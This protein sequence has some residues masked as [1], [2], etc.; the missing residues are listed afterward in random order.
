MGLKAPDPLVQH[1]LRHPIKYVR[2]IRRKAPS[3]RAQGSDQDGNRYCVQLVLEGYAFLKPKHAVAGTAIIGL[4]IG[5]STLA[6]VPQQGKADL[7]TF[8][9][10]LAPNTRNKRRLQ[11]KMER[12]R[13]ANNPENYD[14]LG[15]VK[16]Q[17]TTRLHW[18]ESKRY[19]A[20]RRQHAT[21]ERKLASHR[22]SLHGN[23]NHRITQVGT[24]IKIEKTS[25]KGWQKQYGRSMGLR[26]PGMF[27]AH[28]ARIVAKTGGT[29]SEISAFKTRLS[30][31][32]HQCGHYVKKARS[33]R[34]HT[35]SCGLGPV[36][37]DLY[38]AFLL[39]YLEP[40]QTTPSV[41]QPV[42]EGV[43]EAGSRACKP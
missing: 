23:L 39:A 2:L 38:S 25:F 36:Q 32:C 12:Q 14:A 35:C 26:A 6:I 31:Y 41:T 7:V 40:G 30:Q 24:T 22:K 1:G 3:P 15:R 27:V 16:K 5:P 20:T 18:K 21:A 43:G 17:R 37:R 8:C 29:L 10:E 34:W 9:E 19:K 11:R 33:Q 28:L 13:R 42:W 4:D